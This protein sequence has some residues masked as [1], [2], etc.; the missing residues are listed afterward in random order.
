MRKR[1]QIAG[2][3]Q[4]VGFRPH[5]YRLA[6][7]WG[8]AGFVQNTP[9]GL[10]VE[11]EGEAEPLTGFLAA[12]GRDPPPLAQVA[13]LVVGEVPATGESGFAILASGAGARATGAGIAPDTA[14]CALCQSDYRTPGNRRYSY[15]FTNCTHC[16]PRYTLTRG[17]PYDRPQT[18]MAAFRQCAACQREYDDPASR[19]FH[20]QPNACPECGPEL[21]LGECSGAAALARA[22]ELL[23]AGAILAIKNVGGYQLACDAANQEA[24]ARLRA[25]KRRP[26]KP[27]ALLAPDLA[28]VERV[29]EVDA[30]EQACLRQA[31]RPILLLRR[32]AAPGR[33]L[34]AAVAP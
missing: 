1:V 16:G 28:T 9:S 17:L 12:L 14:P 21:R 32:R 19:R 10:I 7:T 29:C 23:A 5:V 3:V 26:A 2:V 34:A 31:A 22:R 8:L 15:P 6:G 25:R 13:S 20:A 24:V 11:V 18:T 33:A 27:L 30:S 4:G